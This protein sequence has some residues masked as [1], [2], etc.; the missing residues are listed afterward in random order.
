MPTPLIRAAELVRDAAGSSVPIE[1]P[2]GELAAGENESYGA[3]GAVD[4]AV[5][6]LEEAISAYVDWLR[7]VPKSRTRA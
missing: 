5:R 4:F 7:S 6:P 2:G 1:T 3:D